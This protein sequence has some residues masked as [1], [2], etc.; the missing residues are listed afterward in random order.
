MCTLWL[1]DFSCLWIFSVLFS[2]LKSWEPTQF[3]LLTIESFCSID[4][5][6]AIYC[7]KTLGKSLGMLSVATG[8]A[9]LPFTRLQCFAPPF[10]NRIVSSHL[11]HFPMSKKVCLHFQNLTCCSWLHHTSVFLKALSNY[12][13]TFASSKE[14]NFRLVSVASRAASV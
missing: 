14:C 4:N 8:G 10:L 6:S 12:F 5:K 7:T 2:L 11:H 13:V 1:P 9:T 3:Y